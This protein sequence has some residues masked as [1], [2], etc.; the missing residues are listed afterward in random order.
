MYT[1][2]FGRIQ[3]YMQTFLMYGR[4]SQFSITVTT[5]RSKQILF[6]L[7]HIKNYAPYFST[8]FCIAHY[9]NNP[10]YF[11]TNVVLNLIFDFRAP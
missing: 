9:H 7:G 4:V 3:P 2:V 5:Y 6:N 10:L 8:C 1:W 11:L